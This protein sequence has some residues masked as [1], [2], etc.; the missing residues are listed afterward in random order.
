VVGELLGVA[1]DTRVAWPPA[2]P[3]TAGAADALALAGARAFLL[4]ASAYDDNG[5]PPDV[6]PSAHTVF[7]TSSTGAELAGLVADPD[8]SELLTASTP[9]GARVTEQRFLA[10]TAIVAAQKPSVTRTL[11]LALPRRGDAPGAVTEELRDLGRVPWLCP[12]ALADVAQR[13][14]TCA[15]ESGP[16]GEPVERGE[17]RTDQS[18]ELAAPY[19]STVDT[20]RD[21]G[22]QLTDAVLSPAASLRTAVAAMKGR[23]RRAV[24]RAESSAGRDDPVLTRAAARALD[25]EVRRLSR[26]VVVRGGHSLL[27]S[28]K[29]TLSVSVENTL[30]LPVQVRVRFTSKTATLT[31]AE[32]GLVTVQPGH[33]VQASVRARAQ[34][35]GQFVVFAQLVDRNGVPF[36]PESEIIVRSTRFGRLA[37]A[38]TVAAFGVLLAA[39]GVRVARRIRSARRSGG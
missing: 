25:D 21:R 12:V 30:S 16:P 2:G 18:E 8:L 22:T 17:L 31:N 24:A 37:L 29:G 9:Y 5:R 1:P 35:S 14:E 6:T 26:K 4:D 27:T 7:T 39:A 36:G 15:R 32:T 20:D 10:E 13:T 34:R 19:L 33:A 23:L 38:V 28:T 3:V 11:V